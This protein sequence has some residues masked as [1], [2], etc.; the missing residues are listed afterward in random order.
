MLQTSPLEQ[1]D[2]NFKE[3]GDASPA[4]ETPFVFPHTRSRPS[5]CPAMPTLPEE[6]ED[7]PEEMDSS[8]S[9][10]STLV[11]GEIRAVVMTAPTIVY[12][13]QAKVVHQDGRPLEQA[14][15]H[16]PRARVVRSSPGVP[17]TTIA[18]VM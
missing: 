3:S 2:C 8:P 13:K 9:S 7:S 12:P 6:E 10:P 18:Q 1:S 16:S 17:I 5:L 4:A 14:R 15:P 11:P